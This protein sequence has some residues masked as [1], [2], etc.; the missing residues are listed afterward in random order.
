MSPGRERI[1]LCGALALAV[2]VPLGLRWHLSRRIERDLEPSLSRAMG[3]GVHIGDVEAGLDGSVRLD[4]VAVG[5]M[6]EARGI[7]AS[8]GLGSMLSGRLSPDEIRVESPALHVH[9][10]D[11]GQS[12]LERL[13]RRLAERRARATGAARHRSRPPRLRRVIVTGGDL[14]VR[15]GHRGSLTL[16][17]VE[18]RPRAGGA[19]LVVGRVDVDLSLSGY[20]ARGQFGRAAADLS[21]PRVAVRRALLVGGNVDVDPSRGDAATVRD[22]VVAYHTRRHAGLQIAARVARA[23]ADGRVA[24]TVPPGHGGVAL[25]EA[26]DAPI[27]ALAGLLPRG[28]DLSRTLWTGRAAVRRHDGVREVAIEGSLRALAVDDRRVADRPLLADVDLSARVDLARGTDGGRV[29]SLRR[30][31]ARS[32]AIDLTASGQLTWPPGEHLP[33]HGTVRAALARASCSR[34]LDSLPL[35]M[36]DRLVGTRVRG[37]ASARLLLDFARDDESATQ[38][39]LDVDVAHCDV[40]SEP[41]E[42]DPRRLAHPFEHTFPDGSRGIVGTG[43]GAPPDARDYAT[44]R[45]LPSYVPAAW[46]AAEDASFWHHHGFD[47]HQIERSLAVDLHDGGFIRG[48]STISQQLVKNAFLTPERSLARK[49]QE[50]VLTWRLEKHLGKRLILE[51]YLNIIELGPGIY[52]LPAAARYWFDEPPRKLTV[53][54]TA[55]LVAITPAPTTL[56]RR[57]RAAGNLDPDTARKVRL[58]LRHM[59]KRGA[60]SERQYRRAVNAPIRL[61]DHAVASR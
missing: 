11:D 50:A 59:R 46:V 10:D 2:V 36:R 35:P 28:F 1:L 17:G 44:L 13:A 27:A 51:R 53:A 29:V 38:M 48:G 43:P 61:A 9:I 7:E 39:D 18:A 40:E 22:A 30:M 52:G 6:F 25:V 55:F 26:R 60:I 20:R 37:E 21:L 16:R 58:V 4:H 47:L 56:S 32:G 45:S 3:T 42:A 31:R 57:I 34:L 8:V 49:F 33:M 19:R 14:V 23:G 15:V 12:N 54:Q 5:Q 24:I 41:P